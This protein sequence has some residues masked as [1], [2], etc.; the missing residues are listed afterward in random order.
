MAAL[1]TLTHLLS[2]P[3]LL[4]A[5]LLKNGVSG[6]GK[7]LFALLVFV[8]AIH[9]ILKN[10]GFLR[11]KSVKNEHVFITGAGSGIGRQMALRLA[12]RGAKITVADLN[13]EAAEKVAKEIV[14]AG[15]Q[16]L[17]VFCNVI[18]LENVKE[19]AKKAIETFGDVTIL[20]NNAGIVSGK[21]LL[22]SPEKL[23]EMTIAVNTTSHAYTVREFLPAMLRRNHG[24]IVTIAS[25]A[26][27]VG[28][29]GLA[30]YCASKFGAVGF[31][32]SL[33]M[34]LNQMKT[35]VK[36]TCICPYFINTGMFEGV[37]SKVPLLFPILS[38]EY[39]SRRIINAILQEETSMVMPWSGNLV[40]FLRSILPVSVFDYLCD[41]LGANSS[42][43]K[44]KGRGTA[45]QIMD[46]KS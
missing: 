11:K 33:R 44:F 34:E 30:D 12:R 7:K 42:M 28:V 8:Y 4:K 13:F 40:Q 3:A 41:F 20:I 25:L 1:K 19:A 18:V 45:K 26:G 9:A 24:H 38:E 16:A 2:N 31:D 5:Y 17:P 23:I 27:L 35:K 29:N 22:D 46:N 21:K 36:T 15:G 39:A 37:S 6:L 14:D 10:N 32:E 43:D